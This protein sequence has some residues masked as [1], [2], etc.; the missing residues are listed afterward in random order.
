MSSSIITNTGPLFQAGGLASGIDTNA[1]VDKIIEAA[2]APMLQVQKTQ[3]AYSV[4]ISVVANLAAKLKAFR[5]AAN[6]VATTGLA[7]I[8]PSSTYSDFTITGNAAS[9]GEFSV[10]VE[11]MARAA[12]MRSNSFSSAQDPEAVGASGNLQFSIDGTT[13]V[14]IDVTGKSLADIAAAIND[15][16]SQVTASVISTG[17]GYRLSVIRKDTGFSTTAEEAL[18]VLQDPGLGLETVQAAQ[19]ASVY[20]DGLQIVRRSNSISNA[21]PGVTLNLTAQSDVATTVNFVRDTSSAA[22]R[23]K[24][25]M[26]AY[27]DVVALLNQQLRPDPGTASTNNAIAGS[28]LFSLQRDMHALLT[29][30]VNSSGAIQTLS[31]LNVALQQDGTL[32][33]DTNRFQKT[34]AEM[35]DSDPQSANLIF[36]KAST[37]LGALVQKLVRR[38]VDGSTVDLPGGKKLYV[39]GALTAETQLLKDNIK[40]LDTTIDYW[41]VRLEQERARLNASFRAMESIL[42]R[43]NDTS[44]YLNQLYNYT[45]SKNNNK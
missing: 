32:A 29:T 43:L 4:Q 1:I 2:S 30:K 25:F 28:F 37:G 24:S 19:N 31:D 44:T 16:I 11:A 14:A 39:E 8:L 38:Q 36:T 41:K 21:I 9:E 17:S 42:S 33:M 10:R 3:A 23:M 5:E 12:K 13:S 35:V 15:T 27:N 22:T 45:V 20:V 40:S 7:P 26:T 18:Q 6:A 34:F